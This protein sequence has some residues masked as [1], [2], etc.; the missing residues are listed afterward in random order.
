M[1]ATPVTRFVAPGTFLRRTRDGMLGVAGPRHSTQ[2]SAGWLQHTQEITWLGQWGIE[3]WDPSRKN[4][5][6]IEAIDGPDAVEAAARFAALTCPTCS[7]TGRL[8][9]RWARSDTNRCPDPDCRLGR[10]VGV[11]P[12]F[13]ASYAEYRAWLDSYAA[14][15]ARYAAPAEAGSPKTVAWAN[16]VLAYPGTCVECG[17]RLEASVAAQRRKTDHWEVRC[18]THGAA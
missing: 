10:R 15:E 6:R 14:Q 11:E 2:R 18:A 17:A 16:A 5:L 4:A 12:A 1:G 13:D 3:E 8:D 7:G 9:A